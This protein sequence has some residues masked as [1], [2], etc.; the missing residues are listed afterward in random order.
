MIPLRIHSAVL[1]AALSGVG[2]FFWSPLVFA[3]DD[4][5]VPSAAGVEVL[6]PVIV[7]G[8]SES[9]SA[10]DS[11]LERKVIQHLPSGNG[12]LNEQLRLLPGLQLSEDYNSAKS[13]GEILPPTISISGGKVYQNNF[14]VDGVANNNLVDPAAGTKDI[15]ND[16]PGHPQ[17]RFL[18]SDLIEN[19]TIYD[20]NVPARFGN[21]AGGVIEATTRDPGCEVEGH[22]SYRTT[23]HQW[24]RFHISGQNQDEFNSGGHQS[25]QPKFTKNDYGATLSFPL[26]EKS[27]VLASWH[28]LDSRIPLPYFLGT[29]TQ[30]R[31][32]Q[33]Y[34]IKYVN[35]VTDD[36]RLE[37]SISSTPYRE[38]LFLKNVKDSDYEV[39]ME[40]LALQGEWQ[41]AFSRG[42]LELTGA[43]RHSTNLRSG[44]Q[45]FRLW[46]ATNSKDWGRLLGSEY[47]SEGG[48]GT[49]EKIQESYDLKSV[50]RLDPIL[51]GTIRH[52]LTTG[53]DLNRTLGS[54]ERLKATYEYRPLRDIN[55]DESVNSLDSLAPDILCN[56][57]TFDCAEGDQF[58]HD[59][60]IYP[61]GK[62]Q[63]VIQQIGLHGEDLLRFRRLELRPGLRFDYNDLM[64]QANLAPRFLAS[65]DVFGSGATTLSVGANR[66][67]G[68][69]LLTYKLREVKVP[70]RTESRNSDNKQPRPWE[71]ASVQGPNVTRFSKLDTPYADEFSVGLEQRV[72]G[73]ILNLKYLRREGRDEF[74][75]TY[76]PMQSDGLQYYTLNNLGRSH[77]ER[78]SLAW[79]RKWMRYFLGFNAS[80]QETTTT[81]GDYDV[82]LER[83]DVSEKVW[84]NNQLI[85]KRDLPALAQNRPIIVNLIWIAELPSRFTFT[86]LSRYR[87]GYREIRKTD[88]LDEVAVYE[89]IKHSGKVIFDWKLGWSTPVYR[90]QALGFSLEVNNV[91]NSRIQTGGSTTTYEM[92]RQ[93]WAGVA[94]DF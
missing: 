6:A 60:K 90:Q 62:S 43:Y 47:S 72:A 20:S 24:T 86:N 66:Y 87:S 45:H 10:Q 5:T 71:T 18:H 64:Q 22:L 40:G 19:V 36:D 17:E 50:L 75:R 57:N 89:E 1:L 92:G 33:S 15:L 83:E 3:E 78:Y 79:Q 94:Y 80:W 12:S 88:N 38:K 68:T 65:Y 14:L 59:R 39:K 32:Q 11:S 63:A 44:P 31:Q 48:F 28:Q 27:G 21:F 42:E 2:L 91:F 30:Q 76:S 26:T 77:H 58:F 46:T 37:F 34:F 84:Y 52:E 85:Y 29:K 93:F 56:G 55:N 25:L 69:T 51:T 82:Q 61:A 67:Y 53:I 8:S 41:H 74:S 9:P 54:F 70:Y 4:L 81:N 16:T 73:G 35:D 13:G 7:V 23:R 49:V